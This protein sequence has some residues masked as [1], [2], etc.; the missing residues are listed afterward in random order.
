MILL[1]AF[2]KNFEFNIVK[3]DQIETQRV[4]DCGLRNLLNWKIIVDDIRV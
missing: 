2:H 1:V 4:T 3:T